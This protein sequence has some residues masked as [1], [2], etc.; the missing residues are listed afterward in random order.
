[1]FPPFMTFRKLPA[2]SRS[3]SDGSSSF[4]VNCQLLPSLASFVHT[5]ISIN[6][7]DREAMRRNECPQTDRDRC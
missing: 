5:L 1:M 3:V 6:E 7:G 4:D 2:I